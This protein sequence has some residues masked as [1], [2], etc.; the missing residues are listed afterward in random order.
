MTLLPLAVR[1]EDLRAPAS[2]RMQL[3]PGVIELNRPLIVPRGAR[4]LTIVGAGTTLRASDNFRGEALIVVRDAAVITFARMRLDGN[5]GKLA[6]AM[7]LPPSDRSFAEFTPLNGILAE[8]VEGLTVDS[9]EFREVAGF[10]VVAA[11]SRRVA[12]SRSRV[13]DSGSRNAAG[14]NNATGGV[15]IEEG[16]SDFRVERCTFR[17]VLGNAVW[18]H[19]LYTSPRNGPGRIAHNSFA[20]IGRDAIQVGHATKVRVEFNTGTRIGYPMDAVDVEGGGTPVAIDTAGNVDASTYAGNRFTEIN[21]K[22]IDLDGFHHG[23]VRGNVCVNRSAAAAYP[24]GHYGIVF[25]NTNPDMQSDGIRVIG[26]HIEGTKYGGI[27]LIGSNHIVTN[28]RLLRLNT[29]GC[30]ESRL[31]FGC[32]FDM[33]QPDLLQSGIYLGGKAD[34]PAVTRGNT[35]RGNRIAGHKMRERCIAAGPGVTASEQNIHGNICRS[36]P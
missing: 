33:Q 30:N 21:G 32:L 28:N 13:R 9:V 14:R 35:I 19:S 12:I 20:D 22:C 29:A 17:N 18:T 25:N 16:S 1:G 15:L 34:R 6:R 31:Q 36:V 23:D 26:N 4:N 7:G 5:R 10:A 24:F 8:R 27:F 2:G 3:P 11:A